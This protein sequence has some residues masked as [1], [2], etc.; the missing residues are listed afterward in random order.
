MA[1]AFDRSFDPAYGEAVEIIP[2]V[3]RLT[4]NNPG[5]YTFHGTNTYLIGT[6]SLVVVDPGPEDE[7]HLAA[8]L[9]AAGGAA[10]SHILVTHT[11][12]D[13]SPGATVLAD[14]TGARLVGAGPH[15]FARSLHLGETTELDASADLTFT[16]DEP[17]ADGDIIAAP[18]GLVRALATPGHAANHLCFALEGAGL[19]FSGDHV[20]AWS[21]SIVAPP[22]G[23]M[24]DYMASLD[25]L[26][27][28]AETTYLPGHGAPV[29]N[30]HH[31]VLGLKEHRHGREVAVLGAL[32]DGAQSIPEIVAAVYRD[33]DPKL[34]GAAGLSVF[35]QLEWLVQKGLVTT[36]GEP[37]LGG[38][39]APAS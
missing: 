10:I 11:H 39:Y 21:T 32:A 14:R 38:R 23:S 30:A 29:Q 26:L 28:E 9:H 1:L 8:I 6:N 33:T 20:M 2:G 36:D 25:R 3:R 17:I 16:P 13:H 27:G 24:A 12:R 15:R 5:G 34:W 18:A 7:A 31:F 37:L 22:D 19:L 4:A 35:A